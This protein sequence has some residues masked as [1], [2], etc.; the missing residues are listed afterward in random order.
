MKSD[1]PLRI[2]FIAS[3]GGAVI[4]ACASLQQLIGWPFQ[5]VGVV[6]DR[7]CGAEHVARSRGITCVQLP[8]S[9]DTDAWSARVAGLLDQWTAD[10][11]VLL[12]LRRIG[13]AIWQ[14]RQRAVWNLHPSLLPAYPGIDALQQSHD[15]A[16]NTD[17]SIDQWL[18][19]TLHAV[20]DELD[21]GPVISQSRF[22]IHEARSI[23]AARHVSF[24]QKTTLM[25]DAAL[26]V[27]HGD[28]LKQLN[29][30]SSDWIGR[31]RPHMPDTTVLR[32]VETAAEPW[33]LPLVGNPE[34]A[35]LT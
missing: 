10:V 20:T 28:P 22:S 2:A 5:Y 14:S 8:G 11:V 13:R 35:V 12:F 30:D 3:S 21:A 6:T 16:S 25:L 1:R 18:G 33:A 27:H 26:R 29:D 23:G 34:Q 32:A 24:L 4:D 19:T 17:H 15:A 31:F 9:K 7:P